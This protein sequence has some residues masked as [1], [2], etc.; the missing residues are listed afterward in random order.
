MYSSGSNTGRQDELAREA[1]I[2]S[3]MKQIDA[4]FAGFNDDFYA[5]RQA[6]YEASVTPELTAQFD[7]TKKNLAFQLARSGISTSG[8]A[9]D[10]SAS[11]DRE[12]AKKQRE[13]ENAAISSSNQT[14]VDVE[15]QRGQL[16]NQLM[17][18]GDPATTNQ[19]LIASTANLRAPSPI[20]PIGNAFADW[21]SQYLANQQS[22]A[23]APTSNPSFSF[24]GNN[25]P[26][27]TII[28]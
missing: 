3:G 26:E 13:V 15:S 4:K 11:L 9:V 21:S 16:T 27:T 22:R 10:E 1:R 19:A 12:L 5:K 7:K 6:D 18:S 8:A 2:K 20:G 17:A 24:G 25:S 23:Y 28:K 14:R